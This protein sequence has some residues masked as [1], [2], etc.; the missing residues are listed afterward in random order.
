MLNLPG[1]LHVQVQWLEYSEFGFQIILHLCSKSLYFCFVLP[2]FVPNHGV[3]VL[4][5]QAV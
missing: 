4:C 3:K 5:S 2:E 1:Y